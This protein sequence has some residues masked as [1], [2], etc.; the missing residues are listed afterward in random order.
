MRLR[1]TLL[2]AILAIVLAACNREVQSTARPTHTPVP[3][4]IA[5]R[6]PPTAATPA[7]PSITSTMVVPA[8]PT[9]VQAPASSPPPAM[10]VDNTPTVAASATAAVPRSRPS[11]T[12]TSSGPL[13]AMIYVAN[14]RAAPTADKPGNVVVQI[15]V[16]ATGGSGDYKYAYQG[17]EQT[18]K[19]IDITWEKGTR[20]IGKVTVT[21]GDGQTIDKEFDVNTGKL[22]CP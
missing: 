5:T 17:A 2:Y 4:M 13:S 19:F 6:E 22:T 7:A 3:E 8:T 20:L 16:E 11:L 10:P 9:A 21:S 14:C 1:T 15:S 12:P 18:S